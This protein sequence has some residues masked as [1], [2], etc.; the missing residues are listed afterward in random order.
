MPI[1]SLLGQKFTPNTPILNALITVYG[2]GKSVATEACN[3]LNILPKAPI[4]ALGAEDSSKRVSLLKTLAPH[5]RALR[6]KQR[7]R[8]R[9]QLR[10]RNPRYLRMSAGLPVRGQRTSTNAKT[11]RKVSPKLFK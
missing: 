11:S 10:K 5:G 7:D 2:I 1:V 4:H 6:L 9:V 8:A 3:Q